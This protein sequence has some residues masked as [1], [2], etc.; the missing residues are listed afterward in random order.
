MSISEISITELKGQI[1]RGCTVIDVRETDEYV[2]GHVPG[3]LSVPLSV[4]TENVDAFP[5]GVVTYV[6]CQVGGRSLRACEYLEGLGKLVV[7][8]AGGT[9]AWTA[10]GNGVV[11]GESPH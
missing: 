2:A 8:V 7:N 3:A 4:L 5:D 10:T 1:D 6:I 9:G 11:L